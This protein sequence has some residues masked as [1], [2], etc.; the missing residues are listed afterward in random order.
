MRDSNFQAM[1]VDSSKLS[2]KKDPPRLVLIQH[3]DG[4]LEGV[5]VADEISVECTGS[6]T[7]FQL[8]LNLQSAYYA[9]D[10]SYPKTYQLLAFFQLHMLK[11]D[12]ETPEKCN[13][14]VK[15]EKALKLV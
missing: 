8:L 15:L 4:S 3:E 5:I 10:L 13:S 7:M 6:S 11:D 2:A 12:R 14:L 1:D 9:W